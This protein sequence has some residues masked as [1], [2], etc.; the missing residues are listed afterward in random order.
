ME[1][2]KH[3][4]EIK[5]DTKTGKIIRD[6]NKMFQDGKFKELKGSQFDRD[7]PLLQNLD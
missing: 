2:L 7:S 3:L 1:R 5:T 4:D 6:G